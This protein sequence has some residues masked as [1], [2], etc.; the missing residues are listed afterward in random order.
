MVLVG[1]ASAA[2]VPTP[3]SPVLYDQVDF[4]AAFYVR[5]SD[6]GEIE[7][8]DDA[9]SS[10]AADDFEVPAHRT[11][12]IDRIQVPA[13]AADTETGYRVTFY[14]HDQD[15]FGDGSRP[16]AIEA[17]IVVPLED[18]T[19]EHVAADQ[20]LLV[21]LHLATPFVA[22]AGRHWVS[23]VGL[24]EESLLIGGST[25][26]H[27]QRAQWRARSGD[28]C[29]EWTAMT[30]GFSCS[31]WEIDDLRFRL[32]GLQSNEP[33][34]VTIQAKPAAIVEGNAVGGADLT[35]G[36]VS[37]TDLEDAVA[38]TAT[39]SDGTSTVASP[40]FLALGTHTISCSAEDS[41]GASGGDSFAVEI[42]DTTAPSIGDV[43]DVAVTPSSSTGAAVTYTAPAATDVVDPAPAVSCDHPSGAVFPAGATTVTCTATD[44]SGNTSSSS[45]TVTVTFAWSGFF[46]P[47]D[48]LPTVNSVKHGSTVPVKWTLRDGAGGFIG[49][50]T[51]VASITQTRSTCPAGAPVDAVEQTV[52]TGGTTLRWDATA[53][54]YVYNW[55]TPSTPGVCWRLA[56]RLTDGTSHEALFKLK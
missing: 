54:Q 4:P 7:K 48:N 32:F 3:A 36:P 42:V 37:V 46:Q 17:T 5:S 30:A 19:T 26:Q 38:P 50:T 20:E 41:D 47:I 27:G 25:A 21:T 35:W 16:G 22:E 12:T 1:G 44:A 43:D 28:K 56:V 51:T 52:A 6:P 31:F 15:A 13:A 2:D 24:G 34:T 53:K 39:C 14:D 23:I 9:L 29:T 10:E 8:D 33:P 18:S 55:T 49:D 40:V 45:F 11:W